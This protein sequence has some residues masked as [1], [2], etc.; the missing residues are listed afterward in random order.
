MPGEVLSPPA[1]SAAKD[2]QMNVL[3]K[4]L[5]QRPLVIAVF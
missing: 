1:M 4:A 3:A 5:S 2:W